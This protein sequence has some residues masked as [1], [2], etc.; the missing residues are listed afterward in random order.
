[1]KN[2]RF[3]LA[4]FLLFILTLF[5]FPSC[6]SYRVTSAE[7]YFSLG[8]A[9]F[10]LGRAATD[11][12]TRVRYFLEAEKWLNR[13]RS[14]DKTKSASEYNIGRIAFE[15]GRFQDAAKIFETIL[16]RDPHNTFALRAASYTRIRTGDMDI[17]EAHYKKLLTLVPENVDDGYNYA[18]VLYHMERFEAAEQVLSA[19]QYA[20]LDN[21][22]TLLLYARAQKAQDKI[23]AAETYSRWLVN[24]KDAKVRS[25]YAELLENHEFYARALEEYRLALEELSAASTSPKKSDIMFYIARL[26]LIADS[27]SEEGIREL[28][29]ARNEGFA[30]IELLEKLAA[31]SRIGEAHSHNLTAIINE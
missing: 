12:N 6:A 2:N 23:E 14:I 8:M 28:E 16:K 19:Y 17:A 1:M 27:A 26:L 29:N 7:E 18:L 10:D 4:V 22:D 30:D 25:E 21:R 24:N 11:N 5:L 13:A 31:D 15:T 20:L 9:Y 3:C